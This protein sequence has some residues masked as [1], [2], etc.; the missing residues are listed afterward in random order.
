MGTTID[1]PNLTAYLYN[2]RKNNLCYNHGSQVVRALLE[3]DRAL[4]TLDLRGNR[5]STPG[6]QA[7][8]QLLTKNTR[9]KSLCL[10]WNSLGDAESDISILTEA[11]AINKTLTCLDLRNNQL[12]PKSGAY[13]A[14]MLSI[15]STLKTLDLRW[16]S[17][18]DSAAIQMENS[19]KQNTSS[20]LQKVS[21]L[22]YIN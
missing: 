4:T 12:S 6:I 3:D 21:L 2:D 7:L 22:E 5:I 18:D 13:L 9:L 15:N 10:E 14:K 16:N 1:Y 11:L 20:S 8:A 17:I 19:V